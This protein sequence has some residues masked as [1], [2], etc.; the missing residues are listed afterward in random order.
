[1]QEE[2]KAPKE[3][4]TGPIPGISIEEFQKV[5]LKVVTIRAAERVPKADKLLKLVVEADD[6]L[7]TVV[8]GVAQHYA[9]EDLIGQQAVWVSN[10]PPK[11]LRGVTSEGMLL[12]AEGEGGALVRVGPERPVP[13]GSPVK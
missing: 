12:F 5:C 8:S 4:S 1:M 9:P 2:I 10:L 13:P 3:P 7:H 6:G 11:T